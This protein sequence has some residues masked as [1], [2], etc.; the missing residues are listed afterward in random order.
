M[1]G[2]VGKRPPP[3]T[4]T[5]VCFRL[6]KIGSIQLTGN[7]ATRPDQ[8]S[9]KRLATLVL[10]ILDDEIRRQ[11]MMG[12]IRAATAQPEAARLVRD[13][14]TRT[15]IAPTADRLGSKDADSRAGLVMSQI[16]G[17]RHGSAT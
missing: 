5:T 1:Q 16:A 10:D 15:I 3:G 2:E 4:H 13:Y 14:L 12:M 9:D 17:F 11:P 8:T 6:A 7:S